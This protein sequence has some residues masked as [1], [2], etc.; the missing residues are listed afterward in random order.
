M[1]ST[2]DSCEMEG[3]GFR[4]I[5]EIR[6]GIDSNSPLEKS[7]YRWVRIT[8][9]AA[10]NNRTGFGLNPIQI[11]KG[12][13]MNRWSQFPSPIDQFIEQNLEQIIL[14][15]NGIDSI[16]LLLVFH[17]IIL[18]HLSVA[19]PQLTLHSIP[20]RICCRDRSRICYQTLLRVR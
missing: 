12:A 5:E 16:L 8:I 9:P 4:G 14:K 13:T 17:G 15:S 18:F 6:S 10:E 7:R 20:G 11:R 3:G 2:D 19:R 1:G